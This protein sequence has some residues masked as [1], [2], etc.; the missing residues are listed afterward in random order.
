M[1]V[2]EIAKEL[3]VES[4]KVIDFLAGKNIE[5]SPQSGLEEAEESMIRNA[6]APKK[7]EKAEE[8]A[9]PL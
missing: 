6:F 2:H 3:N 9:R 1:R 8:K 4:R 5:K 7:E